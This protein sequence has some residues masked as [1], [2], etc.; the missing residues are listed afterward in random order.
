MI[1]DDQKEDL[2]FQF[3]EIGNDEYHEVLSALSEVYDMDDAST[4]WD[5]ADEM[6][7]Q[8][9]FDQFVEVSN[10]MFYAATQ[11]GEVFETFIEKHKVA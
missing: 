8:E 6:K 3:E 11:S 7:T 9:A 5:I 2:F 10:D 1:L 4:Y